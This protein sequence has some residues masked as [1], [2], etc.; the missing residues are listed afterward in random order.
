MQQPIGPKI[1]IR[2]LVPGEQYYAFS[3]RHSSVKAQF[4]GTFTRYYQNDTGYDMLCFHNTYYEDTT[5]YSYYYGSPEQHQKGC[6]WRVFRPDEEQSF[7]YYRVSRL[8]QTQKKELTTRVTLRERRQYERGLTGSTPNDMWFPRDLV[9]E[10]SLNYLTDRN[11]G[12]KPRRMVR[13]LSDSSY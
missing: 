6:Y 1:D 2:N 13:C 12:T 10:I 5:G 8:T 7:T 3:N 11:V 4:R 9:R